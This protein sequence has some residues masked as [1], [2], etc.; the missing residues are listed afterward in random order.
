MKIECVKNNLYKAISSAERV[1]AKQLPLEILGSIVLRAKKNV[2]FVEATNLSVSLEYNVPAKVVKEGE[3]A[4]PSKVFLQYIN[5]LS[6]D[7]VITLELVENNLHIKS[8]N[9]NS[10]VKTLSLDDFPSFNKIAKPDTHIK[11]DSTLFI[12]TLKSVVFAASFSDIKP[13]IASVNIS[14]DGDSLDF[15]A[16]DS[17]RLAKQKI[18]KGSFVMDGDEL[19]SVIIPVRNVHD[20]IRVFDGVTEDLALVIKDGQAALLSQNIYLLTQLIDGNF[21]NVSQIFPKGHETEVIILK[22]DLTK[23]LR[24]TQI[25]ADK[26]NRVLFRVMPKEKSF[27]IESKN[28]DTGENLNRLEATLDGED[29]AMQFN[30]KYI[31]DVLNVVGEDSISLEFSGQN[32]PMVIKGVGNNDF[33]YLLMPLRV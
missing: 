3:V 15:I 11:I 22:Q 5:N 12:E 16:T 27:E 23:S 8:N 26:F 28:Q 13:E 19:D 7:E 32:K 20:I 24:M 9:S 4:V 21:P 29:V 17:F 31:L 25:F 2:F 33:T 30:G 18:R 6:D 14:S 1:T 10:L